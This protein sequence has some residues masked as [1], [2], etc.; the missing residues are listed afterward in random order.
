MPKR[1]HRAGAW[2]DEPSASART[3]WRLCW[4]DPQSK[5]VVKMTLDPARYPNASAREAALERRSLEMRNAHLDAREGL[6]TITVSDAVRRY[7]ALCRQRLRERTVADYEKMGTM[8]DGWCA[9]HRITSAAQLTPHHIEAFRTER[10]TLL[11][12]RGDSDE[13]RSP[14]TVNVELAAVHSML[15]AWRRLGWTPELTTDAIA[16]AL[17]KEPVPSD[18]IE[19]L[20]P[21]RC[22]A[23]LRAWLAMDAETF[24]MTRKEKEGKR[25]PGSTPRYPSMAPFVAT[26]LLSGMRFG[27]ALALKWADVDLDAGVI[28][29][30]AA[31]TKTKRARRFELTLSPGLALLLRGMW[32]K[33]MERHPKRRAPTD[34]LF[35][36]IT[37]D[38]AEAARKRLAKRERGRDPM[39]DLLALVREADV[40]PWSFQTLRRTCAT[41]LANMPG[42]GPWTEAKMLGH[43]VAVSEAR[44]AGRMKVAATVT[45]IEAALGIEAE[46][47]DIARHVSKRG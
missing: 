18:D 22:R 12:R 35:P 46:V 6:V 7:L 40:G 42:V 38:V 14:G 3:G 16:D 39:D 27:E 19:F 2:L 10:V 43:G 15:K 32:I 34:H 29:L 21:A 47:L 30:R 1:K 26:V 20:P 36:E 8:F 37:T 17:R 31:A 33:R 13:I 44:Y 5:R 24:A 4:R 45:S 41:A 28:T 9:E 11:R 23:L 25:K